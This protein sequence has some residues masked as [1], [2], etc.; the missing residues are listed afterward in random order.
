MENKILNSIK[1]TKKYTE[2]FNI[3]FNLD[4][5]KHE[6]QDQ[7][8]KNPK[9]AL[10]CNPCYGFG[11]IIFCLKIY[12]YLKL[13]YN[14]NATIVTTKPTPFLI[15]GVSK[16]LG[17]KIPNHKFEECSNIKKMEIYN[18]S[19]NGEFTTQN[20]T[21]NFDLIFCTPWIGTDYE[22]KHS[23]LRNLFPYSNRFNTF[24]FSE[25]NAPDLKKYDFP[26]GIGKNTL[27]IFITEPKKTKNR[28]KNPYI[29]VHM[30]QDDRVNV[31]ACFSNFV[32]LMCKKYYK[33][34]NLLDIFISPHILNN[35]KSINSLV[36][37]IEDNYFDKVQIVKNGDSLL[38]PKITSSKSILRIR[39][40]LPFL[41]YDKY[42]GL[43]N[44]CLPDI[45]ITGDQSLS[46]II[47]C[48][49]NYNVYY[50]IM[51]W[52]RNLA[53]NLSTSLGKKGEYLGK[54]RSSCGLEKM[55]LKHKL[56][57][58]KIASK[59]DFTKL[60]KPK[61]DKIIENYYLLTKNKMIKSFVKSV[62]TSRKKNSVLN[63]FQKSIQ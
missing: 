35:Q 15:N 54:I 29:M 62:L 17:A 36:K 63:K 37:Y 28:F 27:G 34:Y 49:K 12:K 46:D 20:K 9:I 43:F 42:V 52:K 30:T 21:T 3:P 18:L 47:S 8:K 39:A 25:Y 5:S 22:P 44:H 33:T 59:Y 4:I 6:D 57:L 26:T 38:K 61:L 58:Q 51:P 11:D 24:L 10:F 13:W 1:N 41:S 50:Q 23:D 40:D 7:N 16:L 48:C 31:G 53:K 32:K 45:L 2:L 14:I 60:A 19:E 55:S 56:D